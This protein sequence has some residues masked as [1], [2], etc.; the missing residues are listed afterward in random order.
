M[1]AAPAKGRDSI[2]R[3]FLQRGR[4]AEAEAADRARAEDLLGQFNLWPLRGERA[5]ALSGGQARLLEF[6]RIMMSGARIALL[7][8]PLAGVNP[9]MADQVI[10]GIESLAASGVTV[11]LIEHDLPTIR[12]LCSSVIAMSLGKI[13]L[14]GT[15]DELAGTEVFAEAYLGAS[16]RRAGNHG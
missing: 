4:I 7:D 16:T 3:T 2:W 5:H 9:V 14:E 12:R 13:V 10:S 11:L 6:G 1:A 15:L 8:E